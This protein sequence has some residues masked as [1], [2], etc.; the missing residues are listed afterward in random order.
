MAVH[1]EAFASRVAGMRGEG[2][3]RV[4][5]QGGERGRDVRRH[6]FEQ[7]HGAVSRGLRL[8]QN[9]KGIDVAIDG[10]GC[11][12]GGLRAVGDHQGNRLA[13]IA[14]LVRS[15]DSL[16]DAREIGARFLAHRDARDLGTDVGGGDHRMYARHRARALGADRADDPMR[17]RRPQ[18]IRM[19]HAGPRDVADIFAA[20]AQETQILDARNGGADIGIARL[21]YDFRCSLRRRNRSSS[22]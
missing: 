2:S 5:A 9:R 6:V 22:A 13:G 16:L 4:A 17:D 7:K 1:F 8:D 21:H 19:Q 12:L 18:H 14:D 20:A 10:G 3:V 15:D 11:V